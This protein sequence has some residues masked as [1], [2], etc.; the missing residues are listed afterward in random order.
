MQRPTIIRPR[1]GQ[2]VTNPI[3]QRPSGPTQN[4]PASAYRP[5]SNTSSGPQQRSAFAAQIRLN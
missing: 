2:V 3:N 1:P 4:R 5:V